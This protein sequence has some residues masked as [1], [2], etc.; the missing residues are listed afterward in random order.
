MKVNLKFKMKLQVNLLN[1]YGVH[2]FDMN[3]STLFQ[4]SAASRLRP[5]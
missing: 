4:G 2:N 1:V 3:S 5:D